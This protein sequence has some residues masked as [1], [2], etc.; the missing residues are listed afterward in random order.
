MT[1]QEQL[2]HKRAAQKA[3]EAQEADQS[4]EAK[5]ARAIERIN[6]Q[7]KPRIDA[8]RVVFPA[9]PP[10]SER[11]QAF[12]R[13]RTNADMT[14]GKCRFCNPEPE[15]FKCPKCDWECSER[16]RMKLHNDLEPG[17]CKAR[18]KKKIRNW[19]RQA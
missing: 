5:N 4:Y 13:G 17:W 18:Y 12:M 7:L 6:R 9:I 1:M 19:S 14:I 2:L 16:W 15:P 11:H 10:V 3:L 8:L